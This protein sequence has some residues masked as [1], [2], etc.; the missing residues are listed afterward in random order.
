MRRVSGK[1]TID[2]N[3]GFNL[4]FLHST[5]TTPGSTGQ[6][7]YTGKEKNLDVLVY[8]TNGTPSNTSTTTIFSPQE[9]KEYFAW[10]WDN[11]DEFKPVKI[12]IKART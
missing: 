7:W 1:G 12:W 2:K 9:A 10:D 5:P 8:H 11:N 6:R 3:C 4:Q